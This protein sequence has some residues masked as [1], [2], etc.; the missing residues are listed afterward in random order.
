MLDDACAP[1]RKPEVPAKPK[2]RVSTSDYRQRVLT[3][4]DRVKD[5]PGSIGA[6]VSPRVAERGR[7]NQSL[8]LSLRKQSNSVRQNI[9]VS[10]GSAA[11]GPKRT[12]RINP[13]WEPFSVR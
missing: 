10:P 13:R 2:R 1:H 6:F 3:E 9:F 4:T 11:S 8:T 7:Q 5:E 12:C